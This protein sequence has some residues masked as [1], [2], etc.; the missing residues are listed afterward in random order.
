MSTKLVVDEK[1][2]VELGKGLLCWSV[3]GVTNSE[4][5]DLT[6]KG[7]FTLNAP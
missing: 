2:D 1:E 5:V 4:T 6:Y 7:M 3:I